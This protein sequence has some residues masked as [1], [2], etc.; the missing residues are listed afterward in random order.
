MVIKSEQISWFSFVV[1]GVLLK[2]V[3]FIASD[4][5]AY[6]ASVKPERE[7]IL[8]YKN[9][10]IVRLSSNAINHINFKN[11]RV[12]KI[13]G[14]PSKFS[15]IISGDGSHLFLTSK[16]A[17]GSEFDISVVDVH[18]EVFDLHVIVQETDKQ[19]ILSLS[20]KDSMKADSNLRIEAAKEMINAMR[21]G[22]KGK[23]Y[24]AITD[25]N[26]SFGLEPD[27]E[28]K[29]YANYRYGKIWGACFDVR[30]KSS[31][32]T[33]ILDADKITSLFKNVIATSPGQITIFPLK[34]SKIFIVFEGESL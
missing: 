1:F 8:G 32:N 11:N 18:A 30:N 29:Q 3:C 33:I 23:Y 19:T 13:I 31:E 17:A 6:N 16:V 2:L 26:I 28:I 10:V 4:A 21:M 24:V 22:L 7:V 14:D 12:V 25:R 34:S 15:G 5:N 20:K 27:L 9:P